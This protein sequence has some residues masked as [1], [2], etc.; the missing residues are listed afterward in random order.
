MG[1]DSTFQAVSLFTNIAKEVITVL[2]IWLK[3]KG[4]VTIRCGAP[5]VLI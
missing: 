1:R 2:S 5:G 3:N 4:V